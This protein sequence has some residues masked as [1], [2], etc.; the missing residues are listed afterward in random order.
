[1]VMNMKCKRHKA[2]PF[3]IINNL[4]M[5]LILLI[6][7]VPILKV[8]ADSLDAKAGYSF[9]LFPRQISLDAYRLILRQRSL[10]DSF[11]ISC[12]VTAA[13]T[14]IAM[15]LTTTGAFVLSIRDL[16]GRGVLI[17]MVMFTMMFNGGIIP[18]Y[19]TV[20]KLG[21][22]DTLWAVILPLAMSSYNLILMK[23]FFGDIPTV[24]HESA[25]L[26][27]AAPLQLYLCIV[28]PISV[29]ALAAIGLFYF[30]CYWNDW[31]EF[32]LYITRPD[33]KNLQVLLREMVLNSDRATDSMLIVYGNALKNAIIILAMI[34]VLIIYPFIQR[35]FITGLK[36][37][38]VK[39]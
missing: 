19:M 6:I 11:A 21:L 13:G 33:L 2:E 34:P 12:I 35:Y 17:F 30:V 10:L 32:T 7:L 38:A 9:N 1:M 8:L 28:L 26:D 3:D 31:Y 5:L 23:N 14:V 39:E 37:G 4:I 20:K 36:L 18:N 16:P 29:P 24:L 15:L 22:V 25:N 27:G